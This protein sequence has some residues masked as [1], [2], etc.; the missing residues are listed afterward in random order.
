[1]DKKMYLSQILFAIKKVT[2]ICEMKLKTK[3][4]DQ[5]LPEIRF[6]FSNLA[7]TQLGWKDENTAAFLQKDRTTIVSARKT[8]K[9]YLLVDINYKSIYDRIKLE[10]TY[11]FEY[12]PGIEVEKERFLNSKLV[13][14]KV[15]IGTDLY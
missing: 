1:M 11:D 9:K 10:L 5:P 3:C 14:K 2:G 8:H 12:S 13:D 7:R 6:M 4:R 15:Y